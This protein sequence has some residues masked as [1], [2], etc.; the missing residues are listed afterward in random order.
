VK[1]SAGKGKPLAGVSVKTY[2]YWSKTA[3]GDLNGADLLSEGTSDENG[4]VPV[5]DGD[6]TYAIQVAY[7]ASAGKPA[8]TVLVLKHFE[9]KEYPVTL[10]E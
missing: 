1:L 10:P 4:R 8:H 6:L 7:K 5:I 9:D 2:V 3:Q